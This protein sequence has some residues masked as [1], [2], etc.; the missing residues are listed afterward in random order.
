MIILLD[1]VT[2]ACDWHTM[3]KV[4]L[5]HVPGFLHKGQVLCVRSSCEAG[6]WKKI[7]CILCSPRLI[8]LFVNLSRYSLVKFNIYYIPHSICLW[9]DNAHDC[10]MICSSWLP[11][12]IWND[13][14]ITSWL[15]RYVMEWASQ[16]EWN[17]NPFPSEWM[18]SNWS[19]LV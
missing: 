17:S 19:V 16:D 11:I 12:I 9:A 1:I 8:N 14:G 13:G 2:D 15:F 18:R 6:E 7:E 3:A 10:L 5:E 4:W